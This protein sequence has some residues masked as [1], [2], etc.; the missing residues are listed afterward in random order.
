M[1]YADE[2][3]TGG[4]C[5]LTDW[6]CCE[7]TPV[8]G[9]CSNLHYLCNQ[10]QSPLAD[11]LADMINYEWTWKCTG[12]N[13]G[14]TASCTEDMIIDGDCGTTPHHYVCTK[15]NPI[16]KND[17]GTF[18]GWNCQGVNGGATVWCTEDIP[19][20]TKPVTSITYPAANSNQTADFSV[21]VSDSDNVELRDCWYRVRNSTTGW[22]VGDGSNNAPRDCNVD[23]DISVGS[24]SG[25]CRK[26]QTCTVYAHSRDTSGNSTTENSLEV[27]I[28]YI[29][30]AADNTPP[31]VS[32]TAGSSSW[33]KTDMSAT[34]NCSDTSGCETY[35]NW[36]MFWQNTNPG[37]CPADPSLGIYPESYGGP[38]TFT[39]HAWACATAQDTKG[40]RG[41]STPVEFKVDKDNPVIDSFEATALGNTV[42]LIFSATDSLSGINRY[43]IYRAPF[44]TTCNDSNKTSCNWSVIKDHASSE[45]TDTPGVGTW[46]YGLHAVDN[47]GNEVGEGGLGPDKVVVKVCA[48]GAKRYICSGTTCP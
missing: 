37:S 1:C 48:P 47:A 15:G 13:G 41:Y 40:N 5:A 4:T 44:S 29:I 18:Y 10:G 9:I 28:N 39:T 16:N 33:Q 46:W 22:T 30:P 21:S 43:K 2:N 45:D 24:S 8:A 20:T 14:A 27:S 3:P 35:S 32:I 25:D 19:D 36:K 12:Y 23:I 17:Y 11:R 42:T 34:V 38:F 26:G 6:G 7:K 31:A